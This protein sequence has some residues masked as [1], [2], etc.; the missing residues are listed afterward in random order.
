[1]LLK[2]KLKLLAILVIGTG[3]V[4][5]F[6][7]E[8]GIDYEYLCKCFC[9]NATRIDLPLKKYEEVFFYRGTPKKQ[10][11]ANLERNREVIEEDYSQINF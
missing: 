7:K 4:R 8:N 11:M 5:Y 10:N 2:W 3:L 6:K 9:S 1:M